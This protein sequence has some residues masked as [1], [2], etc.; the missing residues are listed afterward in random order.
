MGEAIS[1]LKRSSMYLLLCSINV[2]LIYTSFTIW[3]YLSLHTQAKEVEYLPILKVKH[4]SCIYLFTFYFPLIYLT[5]RI[6]NMF[7]YLFTWLFRYLLLCECLFVS[8]THFS[9]GMLI[10]SITFHVMWMS[11]M[12]YI[13]QFVVWISTL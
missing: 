4:A 7:W 9:N 6:V 8:F 2:M 5:I 10:L 11:F 12:L 3:N 13:Y 1:T